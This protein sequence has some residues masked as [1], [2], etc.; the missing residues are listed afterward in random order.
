MFTFVFVDAPHPM[1]S[2]KE[3]IAAGLDEGRVHALVISLTGALSLAEYQL[4]KVS[5][6]DDDLER[7]RE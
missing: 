7:T 1:D 4:C 5:L 3:D 2:L 6:E